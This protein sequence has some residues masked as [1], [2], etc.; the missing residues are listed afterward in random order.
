M[1]VNTS[2]LFGKN[3]FRASY[4]ELF[5]LRKLVFVSMLLAIVVVLKT[6]GLN[7]DYVKMG[8]NAIPANLAYYILG[9]IGGAIFGALSDILGVVVL[10]Q[11]LNPLLTVTGAL[12]GFIAGLIL[13]GHPIQLWRIIL[14]VVLKALICSIFLNT[15]II[16]AMYGVDFRALIVS[17]LLKNAIEVPL[18]IVVYYI[19]VKGLE[20][21]GLFRQL[22]KREE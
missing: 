11:S 1:T 5:K 12:A 6:I 18:T 13:Y 22:Q 7:N 20:K 9:P 16:S 15:L 19:I 17:R 4:Q 10:G 3:I 14:A 8:L 2:G 21:A